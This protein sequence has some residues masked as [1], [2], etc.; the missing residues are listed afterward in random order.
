L[1]YQREI[2]LVPFPFSDLSSSKLRPV[3]VVSSDSFN[4]KFE[5]FIAIPLTSNPRIRDH[6]V[7]IE[8]KD[9]ESGSI[10]LSSRAKVGRIFSLKQVLARKKFGKL[11]QS[12]YEEIVR[13]L[14]LI[15]K[16]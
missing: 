4:R 1:L 14:V 16:E 13:E 2:W 8:S 11:R 7:V 15:V 6:T 12:T 5:D 9:L 10:P 3:I